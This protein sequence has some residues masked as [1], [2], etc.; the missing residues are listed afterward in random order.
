[1]G[2]RLVECDLGDVD[3]L[4][5]AIAGHDLVV[6]A[7]ADIRS[8]SSDPESQRRSNVEGARNIAAACRM[9]SVGRLIHVSSV[10]AIGIPVS[11]REAAAEGFAFN[12]RGSRYHYHITKKSAEES[13]IQQ[14]GSGLDAVIVNPATLFGPWR[15]GWRGAEIMLKVTRGGMIPYFS[16]GRCIVH[17][18]DVV[19]GIL[20]TAKR[21]RT[22][23][24]YILGGENISYRD[25][26]IRSAKALRVT[27]RLFPFPSSVLSALITSSGLAGR[28]LG[29]R[30]PFAAHFFDNRFQYYS[31]EKARTALDY[32]P[33]GF[34]DI[35]TEF[36]SW[37]V[38][39]RLP[40][41][42]VARP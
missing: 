4:R 25:I 24:R 13:V 33:R 28:V 26:A 39:E 40:S 38:G 42:Q 8:W 17:V 31:W 34:D 22:G 29:T 14:V 9:E 41:P 6:H 2:V 32:A 3:R 12:L 7:A 10:S 11:F 36:V 37:R 5:P 19:E 15:S 23:E 27:P 16:G 20:S 35:L 18:D 1:M 21:G 30:P